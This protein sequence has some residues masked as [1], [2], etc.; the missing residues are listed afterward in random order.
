MA[1]H[2]AGGIK[3]LEQIIHTIGGALKGDWRAAQN[4][5]ASFDKDN[6]SY[7]V[8]LDLV[9]WSLHRLIMLAHLPLPATPGDSKLI[10]LSQLKAMTHWVDALYRISEFLRSA[11]T[12]HLDR[13]H[14]VMALFFMIENPMTGDEFIYYIM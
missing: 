6:P 7:D 10:P 14:I 1:L 3:L 9:I 12:S 2:Q 13:N 8:M 5:S 11:R 4:L